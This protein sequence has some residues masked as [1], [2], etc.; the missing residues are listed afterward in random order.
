MFL[1]EIVK[2]IEEEEAQPGAHSDVGASSSDRWWN[3]PASP[4]LSR[5]IEDSKSI[6]AVKGNFYH[7]I[8]ELLLEKRIVDLDANSY[9]GEEVELMKDNLGKPFKFKVEEEM[10]EGVIMY[11]DYVME[12]IEERPHAFLTI[13]E[14]FCIKSVDEKCFGRGDAIINDPFKT[15]EVVDLK[16]G[17]TKVNPNGKQLKYYA[18]GALEMCDTDVDEVYLTIAQPTESEDYKIKTYVL[19]K[20][21]LME[22]KVE[23]AEAIKRVR[24]ATKADVCEG[25]W[26]R[27]CR[28]N[29]PNICP[30]K[31]KKML[32][33][34]DMKLPDLAVKEEKHVSILMTPEQRVW[35]L[36]NSSFIKEILDAVHEESTAIAKA[37]NCPEGYKLVNKVAHRKAFPE[38]EAKLTEILGEGAFKTSKKLLTYNQALKEMKD[39][40]GVKKK[41]ADG[42]IADLFYTPDNGLV[43]VK[44]DDRRTAVILID[45]VFDTSIL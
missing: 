28:A 14:R 41:K 24:E 16:T 7:K 4:H 32:A 23:L 21:E 19:T 1:E 33:V 27:Y 5:G 13:E 25:D 29:S 37:G 17:R 12:K 10:I 39:S 43:L 18:L 3:C 44:D 26:C 36:D 35:C 9:I 42:M 22:F 8:G 40:K 31:N 45:A 34:I 30:A 38:A 2:E 6:Y 11:K 20:A 15:L